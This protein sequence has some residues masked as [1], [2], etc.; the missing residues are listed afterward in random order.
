MTLVQLSKDS[1]DLG[2]VVSDADKALAFYRDLLG[3]PLQGEM[4]MPGGAKMYRLLCGT[5]LLK[6]IHTP[7]DLGGAAKGGIT[8]ALGYRYFTMYVTNLQE[9]SDKCAAAGYNV[10]IAPVTIRPGVTIAMVEDPDGNWVEFLETSA[11]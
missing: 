6:I 10:A 1:I 7:G 2:I 3:F 5:S 4:P 8:G 11:T 9:I